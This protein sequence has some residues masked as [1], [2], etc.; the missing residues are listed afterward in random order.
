MALNSGGKS[1]VVTLGDGEG[2]CACGAK[3]ELSSRAHAS[4]CVRA[5]ARP[6]ADDDDGEVILEK[7]VRLSAGAAQA[8]AGSAG[9]G[10][11]ASGCASDRARQ[12]L[13]A[14]S[15][16]TSSCSSSTV[17][18]RVCACAHALR[19]WRPIALCAGAPRAEASRPRQS[20]KVRVVRVGDGG[21]ASLSRTARFARRLWGRKAAR[22]V[23]P[24][25]DHAPRHAPSAQR[26]R[27]S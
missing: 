6:L 9:G 16:W 12:S 3:E 8:Q 4:S 19:V 14:R 27:T 26:T 15:Q 10:A 25:E 18:A 2:L 22:K 7:P 13:S 23:R 1:S 24:R 17:R 21:L 5:C 20:P 11:G